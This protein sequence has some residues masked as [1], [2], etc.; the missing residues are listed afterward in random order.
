MKK[1][2]VTI[3]GGIGNQMLQYSLYQH[4]K[5]QGFKCQVY[6]KPDDLNDHHFFN[7]D[8]LFNSIQISSAKKNIDNYL[9]F[10]QF[11]QKI[12]V[13]LNNRFK[14]K[15]FTI[16]NNIL[17]IWVINFPTWH[18]YT[19]LEHE[20][21]FLLKIF[22]FPNFKSVEN[23]NLYETIKNTNSVSIHI[24]RGDYVYN[25]KWRAILGDI[26][27]LYY[28]QSAISEI[29]NAIDNPFFVIFS[30]DIKWTKENLQINNA[31]YV[32]WNLGDES[33]IDMQLMSLCKHNIIANSTFSL[34]A[35]WLN[36]NKNKII[37]APSKWINRHND[38]SKQ[39]YLRRNWT[40]IDNDG[41]NIS[42]IIK[43]KTVV[44]KRDIYNILKQTYTDFELII[45]SMIDY[46]IDDTRIQKGQSNNTKGNHILEFDSNSVKSFKNRNFLWYIFGEYLAKLTNK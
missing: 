20:M 40:V 16:L 3:A 33:Y 19:F 5:N 24:R 30:D 21:T 35:A 12:I 23:N 43:D 26:C 6:L 15:N 8:K 38:N 2:L 11:I 31:V 46:D 25:V 1:Y 7:I 10:Y 4:L 27:S 34:M 37:I 44:K 9:R 22:S 32:D 29:M 42:I 18:N 14:T 39:K 41:P 13:F 45:C 28:Y 36:N 17:P